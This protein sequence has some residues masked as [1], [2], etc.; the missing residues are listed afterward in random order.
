MQPPPRLPLQTP[1]LCV[2]THT[3]ELDKFAPWVHSAAAATRNTEQAEG[4]SIRAANFFQPR[5]FSAPLLFPLQLNP[6][7]LLYVCFQLTFN[8]NYTQSRLLGFL[9]FPC[10]AL[11]D[12]DKKR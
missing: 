3:E 7:F 1:P 4:M 11:G 10:I 6:S 9:F 2:P 5:Q 8:M 12:I